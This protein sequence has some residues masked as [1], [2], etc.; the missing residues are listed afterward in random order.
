MPFFVTIIGWLFLGKSFNR[1]FL[2]GLIMALGGAIS[3]SIE[4]QISSEHLL[5]DVA[6]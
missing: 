1:Y 2:V 6:A 5:G 4:D 3:I